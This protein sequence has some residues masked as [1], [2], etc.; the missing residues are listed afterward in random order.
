MIQNQPI[1]IAIDEPLTSPTGIGGY[2]IIDL[3]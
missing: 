3:A 2:L 1:I